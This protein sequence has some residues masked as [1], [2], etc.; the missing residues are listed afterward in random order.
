[1]RVFHI[2]VI[3]ML[4]LMLSVSLCFAHSERVKVVDIEHYQI[5]VKRDN[6]AEFELRIG[7]GCPA[8]WNYDRRDVVLRS[9]GDTFLGRNS[10]IVLKKEN[11]QC[12]VKSYARL[13]GP[14]KKKKNETVRVVKVRSSHTVIRRDNGATFEVKIGAGC[15]SLWRYEGKDVRISSPNGFLGDGS[16]LILRDQKQQ[17][18]VKKH[19][20]R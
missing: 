3:T 6:G 15:P 14:R 9:D 12:P 11:Q 10:K 8:I 19:H 1:M 20:R 5:V 18:S 13:E 4:S 17:C 7:N 2:C 16:E